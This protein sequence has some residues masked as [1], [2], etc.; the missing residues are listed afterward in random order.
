VLP[1]SSRCSVPL[2]PRT[3]RHRRFRHLSN[4][5]IPVIIASAA[6]LNSRKLK[7]A[8]FIGCCIAKAAM[9]ATGVSVAAE[10]C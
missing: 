8:I 10:R 9:R 5:I 6:E 7:R 1:C 3:L 2:H 4:A